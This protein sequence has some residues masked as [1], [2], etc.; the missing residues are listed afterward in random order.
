MSIYYISY[1]VYE[2][3]LINLR[4]RIRLHESASFCMV[5]RRSAGTFNGKG[6]AGQRRYGRA[7]HM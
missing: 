6:R 1:I 3:E 4:L 5:M 7:Q 2:M